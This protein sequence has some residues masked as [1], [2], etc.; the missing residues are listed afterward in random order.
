MI[1][2]KQTSHKS[3]PGPP[4]HRPLRN[5]PSNTVILSTIHPLGRRD[6]KHQPPSSRQLTLRVYTLLPLSSR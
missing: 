5:H 6:G 2:R 3:I 4:V 1:T